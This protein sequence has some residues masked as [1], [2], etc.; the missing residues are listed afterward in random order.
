MFL[1]SIKITTGLLEGLN[2][3]IKVIQRNTYGFR[4]WIT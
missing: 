1:S 4:I 3:K 2:N